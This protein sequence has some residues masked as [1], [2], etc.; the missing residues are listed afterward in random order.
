MGLAAVLVRQGLHDEAWLAAGTAGWPQ[1]R[2]RLAEFPLERVTEATGLEPQAILDLAHLYAGCRPGLIK[3][4][5]G[6]NRNPNGGQTVRAIC[7]LPALTGQYGVRGSGLAYS[8]SGYVPWDKEAVHHWA[9][10]PPPGRQVNMNRLGAA[11]LGEAADPPIRSLFVFGA[12]PVTSTPHTGRILAGLRRDD[13]FT[14]VHDLFLTDTADH[15]DLVLPATS[16]LEH[17]DLH[18]ASATPS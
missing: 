3:I 11:L 10:C 7:A 5:D 8:T 15:A 12:N 9:D 14:V 2:E 1:F 6:I 17:T 4:A 16:Q 18:K 13:L